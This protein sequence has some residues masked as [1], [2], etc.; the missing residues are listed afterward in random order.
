[1][2]QAVMKIVVEKIDEK[3]LLM[4]N[5]YPQKYIIRSTAKMRALIKIVILKIT[6]ISEY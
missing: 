3:F 6:E 5:S 2:D 1:M 4:K